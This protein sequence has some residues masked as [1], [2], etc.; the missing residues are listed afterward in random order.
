IA[1]PCALGLATPTS[2]MVGTGK[3]AEMGILIKGGEYLERAGSLSAI[4]LDKTGTLTAGRPVLTD[5]IALGNWLGREQEMLGL[6]ASA[7]STS[8]HPLAA[9]VVEYARQQGSQIVAP[10]EFQ[11]LPGFGLQA[12]LQG[13]EVLVGKPDFIVER[14]YAVAQWEAQ[15]A[16]LEQA[17]KTAV[18]VVVE[19]QV[20]G[21]LALA[22]TLKPEAASVVAELH[23]LGMEVW[24]IT[25]DNQRTAQAVA[26]QAGIQ[27][28]LAGV[29]PGEK[30]DKV[31]SLKE[32]GLVVG[33]V[34]DGINDA[35]ALAVADVGFA[36]GS[37][38][39]IAIETA[40][41]TL[42]G[43]SLQGVV[44]AIK[45]SRAT[46]RNIKQNLF[47]AFI[48]NTLG[49]PLAAAGFLSPVV[50]GAAMAFSSVTVVSNALRLRGF[51]A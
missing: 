23:R 42:L 2:I 3:G 26:R 31:A 44:N 7:E 8:E 48:F 33:M 21:L 24:M 41:V 1:C 34:G 37:G 38:T 27:N 36:L 35:P 16:T 18:F 22:D 40:P 6:A 13:L 28:V 47:W 12:R 32:R 43:G 4:V 11:A 14:G 10:E 45:L 15:V 39:D 30:A 46:L 17:G 29:L 19:G 5:V 51:K 20:A 25:G 9:A 50:A 49:I